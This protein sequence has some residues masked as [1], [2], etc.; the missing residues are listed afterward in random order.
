[1][2]IIVRVTEASASLP[3]AEKQIKIQPVG[4]LLYLIKIPDNM[5]TEVEG[6][7]ILTDDGLRY[8]LHK[9]T[10]ILYVD[11]DKDF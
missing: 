6:N 5:T 10:V 4:D 7:K 9:A 11:G 1:M 2:D 3:F 8:F